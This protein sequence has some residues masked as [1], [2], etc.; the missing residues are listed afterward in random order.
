VLTGSHRKGLRMQLQLPLLVQAVSIT[1][2]SVSESLAD[3]G[4]IQGE[5]LKA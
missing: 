3:V 2:Y 1:Y 5:C 4:E